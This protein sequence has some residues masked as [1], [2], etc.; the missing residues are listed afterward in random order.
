MMT[1]IGSGGFWPVLL[2]MTLM[3]LIGVAVLV[4]AIR[5]GRWRLAGGPGGP[6]ST[7]PGGEREQAQ[8]SGPD[9]LVVLRERY[10]AGE[11]D[12]QEFE[13][14]I[15]TLLRTDPTQDRPLP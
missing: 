12:E 9:P 11:I 13:R 4:Y 8:L 5:G 6:R 15:E 3:M 1:G 2:I 14:R 7:L 10:A